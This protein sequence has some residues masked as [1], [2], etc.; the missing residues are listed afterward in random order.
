M[1]RLII[2]AL[3]VFLIWLLFVSSFDRRRK[4]AISVVVL[5]LAVL[6]VWFEGRGET[7]T[8]GRIQ[9]TDIV[10]CGVSASH[11]YRTN[12]DIEFCLQNNSVEATAKRIRMAFIA[13]RCATSTECI[14]VEKVNKEFAI[15]LPPGL[16]KNQTENLNFKA[17]DSLDQSLSWRVEVEQVKAVF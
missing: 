6:A 17:V 5:I 14:E 2:L 13:E 3:G 15:E 9:S 8:T 10:V 4:I 11:S 16:S 12:F 7:P 1:I